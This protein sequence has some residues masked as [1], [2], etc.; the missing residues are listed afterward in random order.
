VELSKKAELKEFLEEDLPELQRIIALHTRT[1]VWQR[2]EYEEKVSNGGG[3]DCGSGSG[4]SH[5]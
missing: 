5:S 3:G 2:K 1:M 4:N